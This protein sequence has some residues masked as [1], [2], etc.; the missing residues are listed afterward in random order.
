MS[1]SCTEGSGRSRLWREGSE[2]C[3]CGSVILAD[4]RTTSS[5]LT[6]ANSVWSPVSESDSMTILTAP[7]LRVGWSNRLFADLSQDVVEIQR[8]E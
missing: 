5:T 3:R 8:A 6:T 1:C 2:R 7:S 4:D